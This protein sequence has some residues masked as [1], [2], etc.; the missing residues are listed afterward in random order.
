MAMTFSVP[1]GASDRCPVRNAV[2]F[3]WRERQARAPL[4]RCVPPDAGLVRFAGFDAAHLTLASRQRHCENVM[5]L[6]RF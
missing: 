5:L 2:L 1:L 4:S 3:G 6:C